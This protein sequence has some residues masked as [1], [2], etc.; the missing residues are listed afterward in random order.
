MVVCPINKG[1]GE[2]IVICK[3][4]CALK[5]GETTADD[6]NFTWEGGSA[7]WS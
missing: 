1:D 3:T 6:E 5:S 4:Q 7:R 2:T